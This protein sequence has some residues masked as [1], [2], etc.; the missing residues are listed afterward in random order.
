MPSRIQCSRQH[1]WQTTPKAVYVGRPSRYANPYVI[2]VHGTREE[3]IAQYR[4]LLETDHVLRAA[5]RALR[6]KD[7]ACWCRLEEACH[8]D[9][10]LAVANG[11]DA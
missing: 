2:G 10:I 5:V 6:G 7:V 9:V 1:P 8:G 11:E 4:A 3:C